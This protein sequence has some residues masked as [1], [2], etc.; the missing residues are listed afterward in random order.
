MQFPGSRVINANFKL[1]PVQ[2]L[3][4]GLNV[5]NLF[6]SLALLGPDNAN[7]IMTGNTF[8]GT[9]SSAIGRTITADIKFSF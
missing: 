6:N 7:E 9:A 1:K 3:Q 8:V 2:N 5:Y 4:F